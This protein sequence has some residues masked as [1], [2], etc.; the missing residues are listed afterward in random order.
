M[1]YLDYAANTPVDPEV[2][3]CFQNIN[4][5]YFANPNSV[6]RM[7]RASKE[8]LDQITEKIV[9]HI[10]VKAS[11]LIYTSGAS[12]AN[13]LAIKGIAQA[14]RHN[15]KHIIS[16]CLEHSS[17]SGALTY[18]QSL[19][20]EIDL[21][22][23]TEDGLVDLEHLKELLRKDTILVSVCYVD[24][25]LGIRQPITEIGR[26]LSEY[27]NCMFHCDATQ[28][29][30]KLPVSFEYMDCM[31]FAP[32][33]FYGLNSCG[34]LVKREKVILT[35]LVHGGI[36]TTIYRSG[37]PDL[38]MAASIEKALELALKNLDERYHIV[39][40]LNQKLRS[41]FEK[42][43]LVRINSTRYSYPYILNLSV[44]GVK[45]T[46]FQDA[47][48]KE[49]VCVSTKSACSVINTPSRPVLA[50]TKDKKNAMSSW[51]ISLSHL[52]TEEDIV[53]FFQAFDRCYNALTGPVTK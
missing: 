1:I 35:P 43:K 48:E 18:L 27:P 19:G 37:T 47:L 15:G 49:E 4:N 45:A 21:V 52:T 39:E 16:T 20:Y 40:E 8:L 41:G 36:S 11:E 30:G 51:R 10:G 14:Y 50:I 46:Q 53:Q 29:I 2:M 22:N 3:S 32:H 17:V 23:I 44:S 6:H 25:E 5:M 24:S 42:Y 33:K 9:A 26:I 12:E 28:A 7:G 31:T 13:N 34:I 38:A